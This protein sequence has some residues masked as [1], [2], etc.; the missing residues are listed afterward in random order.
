MLAFGL[1]NSSMGVFLFG[2]SLLRAS[3]V[4]IL[5][6][7]LK[8]RRKARTS[9]LASILLPLHHRHVL[10]IITTNMWPLILQ[11]NFYC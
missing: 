9:Y 10:H 11:A 7:E 2:V 6:K 8:V 1:E 4:T 3:S 5:I